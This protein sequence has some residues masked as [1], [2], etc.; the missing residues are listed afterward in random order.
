[1]KKLPKRI[2]VRWDAVRKGDEPYLVA[3]PHAGAHGEVN[4]NIVLGVYELKSTGTL[5]TKPEFLPDDEAGE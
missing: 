1:M 2:Y 4:E 5:T 3:Y